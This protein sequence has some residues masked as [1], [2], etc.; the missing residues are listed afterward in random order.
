MNWLTHGR[1]DTAGTN[2]LLECKSDQSSNICWYLEA[3][4]AEV[5]QEQKA[6]RCADIFN[7][8]LGYGGSDADG[9]RIALP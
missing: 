2:A 6:S 4:E 3:E 1:S 7:I 8:T 9:Y 5:N